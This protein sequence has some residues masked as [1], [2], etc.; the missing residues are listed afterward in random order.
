M[1]V[2]VKRRHKV[3][4]DDVESWRH[5]VEVN[6]IGLY[7]VT[8]AF[9]PHIVAD[10]GGKII[11]IGSGMGHAPVPGNS[12]YAV[13]KAGAWMFTQ[14]L[15]RE[16]WEQGRGGQRGRPR[17]GGHAAD[18]AGRMRVGGPPPFDP[19]ERVKA[20]A[21]VA[22][23]VLWLATRPAGGPTAQSFSLAPPTAVAG[24]ARCGAGTCGLTQGLKTFL[25]EQYD[26][27]GTRIRV[28][29]GERGRPK[30]RSVGQLSGERKTPPGQR[31]PTPDAST[32][33]TPKAC[34]TSSCS[35]GTS[36]S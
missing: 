17:A 34:D 2:V 21:E 35:C 31:R 24:T 20:P 3:G 29:S 6:L 9:L 11:N 25:R 27:H 23:L 19:S 12:S 30:D 26:A 28:T 18:G 36:V 33:T 15:A 5:T 13:A 22:E 1:P 32:E 7:L 16:V 14:V 8:R 10:G 4:A